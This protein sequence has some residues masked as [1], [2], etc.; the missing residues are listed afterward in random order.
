MGRDVDYKNR[1][2]F[3][4]LGIAI[5]TLRRIRGFSQEKLSEKANISRSLLSN[6]EAP[7]LAYSFSLDVFYNIADALE[8]APEDLIK[9]SVFPDGVIGN[10]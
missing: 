3:I 7:N 1:D 4:Q 9:A 10:K 2:R 8:I 5:S 6:I